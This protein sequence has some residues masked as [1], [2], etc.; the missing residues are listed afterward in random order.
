[1]IRSDH[2]AAWLLTG[3]LAGLVGGVV[4]ALAMLELGMMAS[5]ALI[6]SARESMGLGLLVHFALSAVFGV[7]FA[8]LVRNQARRNDA[9]VFWGLAYG[10]VVWFLD[11]LTLYPLT[12]GEPV[13]WSLAAAQ[14]SFGLLLGFLLYGAATGLALLILSRPVL[15][16]PSLAGIGL[17]S[18]AGLMAAAIAAGLLADQGQ[19]PMFAALPTDTA[20][21]LAWLAALIIGAVAGAGFAALAQRPSDSAGAGLVRGAMYGFLLWVVLRL[22]V[23]P[24]ILDGEL[25]WSVTAAAA[26]Y[27]ALLAYLVFGGF[28]GLGYQWLRGLWHVLFDDVDGADDEEGVGARGLRALGRGLAAGVVGGL[29]F[30]YVMVQVGALPDVAG[31]MGGDTQIAGL[32]IHLVIAMLFGAAYGLLFRRQSYDVGSAVGWGVSYGFF[33]WVLGPQILMPMLLGATPAWSAAGAASLTA[34]MVGHLAYGAGLGLTY[35]VFETRHNPWWVPRRQADEE[36]LRRRREALQSAAPAL[37]AL[38]L[39][40]GLTLPVIL[41]GST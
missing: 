31:L 7:L 34:S 33:L 12:V 8:A 19:T 40:V 30:T 4:L 37:W 13:T 22:T 36:R 3:A 27:P 5:M 9:L 23:L 28:L 2:L 17:G 29:L 14:G 32:V 11:P 15:R 21:P 1:M 41:G 18:A 26:T 6:V 35:H 39:L 20:Q 16:R 25:P 10:A 38:V 24:L